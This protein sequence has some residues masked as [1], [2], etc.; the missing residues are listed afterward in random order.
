MNVASTAGFALMPNMAAYAASRHAVVGLSEVLAMELH[1]TDISEQVVCPGT[2]N[3]AIVTASPASASIG[4][5][6][7]ERLQR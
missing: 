2:I 5:A 3:T 4:S 7:R 1:G 6:Q